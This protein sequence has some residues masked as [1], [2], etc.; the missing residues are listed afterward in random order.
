MIIWWK[1]IQTHGQEPFFK[2]DAS[3]DAVEN[4]LSECFNSLIVSA[5]RKPII[6]ML[7]EIRLTIMERFEKM[8]KK[9]EK[10][11]SDICP[12]IKKKV[13]KNKDQMRYVYLEFV[14]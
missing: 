7:E 6:T 2:T 8:A 1:E 13:E 9:V 3:C 12:T 4:G 5:R 10:W 14:L 11:N